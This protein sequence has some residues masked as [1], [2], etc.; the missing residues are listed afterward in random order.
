MLEGFVGVEIEVK[1]TAIFVSFEDNCAC[2]WIFYNEIL[3]FIL[4]ARVNLNLV[5]SFHRNIGDRRIVVRHSSL[6]SNLSNSRSYLL[7]FLADVVILY[8]S[9]IFFPVD[10]D[11]I[12][13]EF[14]VDDVIF[15]PVHGQSFKV[16]LVV[17]L[18]VLFAVR[19][20]LGA[21]AVHIS[22]KRKTD[23]AVL[24]V[25]VKPSIHELSLCQVHITAQLPNSRSDFRLDL[26]QNLSD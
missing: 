16:D 18:E 10:D 25:Q 13:R 14:V 6:F 9:L 2:L 15:G 12:R 19:V 17:V 11:G 26:E 21:L 23:F 20:N 5:L 1:V 3:V 22:N 8:V 24:V 4:R 7:K